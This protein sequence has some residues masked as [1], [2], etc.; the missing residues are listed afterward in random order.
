[1]VNEG[2]VRGDYAEASQNFKQSEPHIF[3]VKGTTYLR[4]VPAIHSL[5]SLDEGSTA[6]GAYVHLETHGL[7]RKVKISYT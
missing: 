2:A 4:T 6:L 3:Y 1:M 7:L 5:L